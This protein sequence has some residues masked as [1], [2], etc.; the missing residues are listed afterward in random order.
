MRLRGPMAPIMKTH[1]LSGLPIEPLGMVNGR[2][3]YP[4]MGGAPDD[5]DDDDADKDKGGGNDRGDAGSDG[6]DKDKDSNSGGD[7]TVSREEFER[8]QERMQAAD[9]RATQAEQKVREAEDAKKDDLTKAQDRVT[10]LESEIEKREERIRSL[11]LQ[12]AFLT[13]NEHPW[14]DPDTALDLAERN[15]Y[16]EGVISDAGDVDKTRL[17]KAL[18]RLAKEKK[19]LVQTDDKDKKDDEPPAS[20]GEPAGAR[21]DNSKDDRAKKEQLRRRF[22]VLNR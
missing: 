3:I 14:H 18:D 15:G 4:I 22:P 17:K 6:S 13:A 11:T 12:N 20:S 7:Q 16:L 19:F 1:P 9:R 21:S 8:L 10:E 5:D 2:L